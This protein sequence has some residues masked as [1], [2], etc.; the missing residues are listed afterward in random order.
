MNMTEVKISKI[1]SKSNLYHALT[2]PMSPHLTFYVELDKV[3]PKLI[4]YKR[5][6]TPRFPLSSDPASSVVVY[7]LFRI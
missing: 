2:F 1:C 6:L 3:A 4:N 7:T 5:F